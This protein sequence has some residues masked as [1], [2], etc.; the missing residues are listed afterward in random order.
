MRRAI[1]AL[2]ALAFLFP[3]VT[4]AS[5][6]TVSDSGR[7][8]YNQF[9]FSDGNSATNAYIAGDNGGAYS[10]HFDFLI[11]TLGGTLV[12]ATLNLDNQVHNAG[13]SGP[14]PGPA[15]HYAVSSLG[16]FGTYG[17]ANIGT[18]TLYGTS[19][20]LTGITGPGLVTIPLDSAALAAITGAQGHTFSL[21]G[22]HSGESL[23]F[24]FINDF[25][26]IGSPASAV[27]T[28]TLDVSSAPEPATLTLLGTGFVAM[29][30]YRLSRRR[31]GLPRT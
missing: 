15:T 18:G 23:P 31:R 5:L 10:N 21:G 11:P 29:G 12:G 7:G 2:A 19:N 1:L 13:Y 26:T 20:F 8:W 6:I 27:T 9:G 17:F 14:G 30:T 16:S 25:V 28:L 4:N 3:R 22:I 24:S